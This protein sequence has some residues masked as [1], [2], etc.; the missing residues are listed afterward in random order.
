MLIWPG[1]ESASAKGLIIETKEEQR[2]DRILHSTSSC[3]IV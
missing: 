3:R 1:V 2:P